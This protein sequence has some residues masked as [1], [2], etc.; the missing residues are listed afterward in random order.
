MDAIR[1]LGGCDTHRLTDNIRT[2]LDCRDKYVNVNLIFP[3]QPCECGRA[4][5]ALAFAIHIKGCRVVM[6]RQPVSLD[7]QHF[8]KQ[9]VEAPNVPSQV[10]HHAG[11]RALLSPL[12]TVVWIACL[13]AVI[14]V[15]GEHAEGRFK[16]VQ[17]LREAQR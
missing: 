3:L 8:V 9:F 14:V 10:R 17:L 11:G 6:A 4:C 1:W 7:G 16:V 12:A 2:S 5:D 13:P 15:G